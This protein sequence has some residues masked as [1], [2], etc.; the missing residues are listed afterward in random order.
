MRARTSVCIRACMHMCVFIVCCQFVRVLISFLSVPWLRSV[1]VALPGHI[2]TW[3]WRA[4]R[5]HKGFTKPTATWLLNNVVGSFD[6][7][8]CIHSLLRESFFKN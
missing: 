5:T 1:V 8:L 2:I 7:H 4:P 6:V 3:F